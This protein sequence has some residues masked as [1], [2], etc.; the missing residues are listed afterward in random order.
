MALDRDRLVELCRAIDESGDDPEQVALMEEMIVTAR[1]DPDDV[2]RAASEFESIGADPL[3]AFQL[4]WLVESYRASPEIACRLGELSMTR[5]ID[6]ATALRLAALVEEVRPDPAGALALAATELRRVNAGEVPFVTDF[7]GL[8]LALRR[9]DEKW[10]DAVIDLVPVEPGVWD[11]IHA[12][13]RASQERRLI[14]D[15]LGIERLTRAWLRHSASLPDG[16]RVH[17]WADELV[18]SIEEW[19]D[20]E[21]HRAVLLRLIENAD[22]E[23]I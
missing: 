4:G 11:A 20:E 10:L 1:P 14:V 3:K 18:R 15:R 21:L 13:L 22:D 17:G 5:P 8:F 6:P 9:I 12:V 2:G 23:Q 16:E 7:E 19:A